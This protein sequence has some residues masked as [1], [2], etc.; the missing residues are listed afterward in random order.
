VPLSVAA[1]VAPW[2]PV[3]GLTPVS[4]GTAGAFTVKVCAALVPLP[5]VTVTL[6]APDVAVDASVSVAVS[7]VAVVAVTPLTVTPLPLTATVVV[8]ATKFVP[9]SVAVMTAPAAPLAGV[10]KVSVGADEDGED[11]V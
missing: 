10:I 6:R 11:G 2:T 5:V 9:V 1:T 3:A 4:V 7:D 8:P